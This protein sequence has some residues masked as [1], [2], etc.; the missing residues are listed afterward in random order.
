MDDSLYKQAVEIVRNDKKASTSYIQRKLRIGYNRAADLIDRMEAE[1]IVS[2]ADY[3]GRREVVGLE[4]K[5]SNEEDSLS[6]GKFLGSC[7]C[8]I[9]YFLL[10]LISFL[11]MIGCF[12]SGDVG[13]AAFGGLFAVFCGYRIY[14]KIEKKSIEIKKTY[15]IEDNYLYEKL[16]YSIWKSREVDAKKIKDIVGDE[17]KAEI[18][19]YRLEQEGLGKFESENKMILDFYRI[20]DKVKQTAYYLKREKEEKEVER[21]FKVCQHK[22]VL[23]RKYHQLVYED[24]YGIIKEDKYR[25]ELE[26]FVKNVLRKNE[27]ENS[28]SLSNEVDWVLKQVK[29]FLLNENEQEI[30]TPVKNPYD[31]EKQ[32]ADILNNHGWKAKATSKSLDQGVDVIAEKDGKKIAIQC[33]LYSQPVGNKAVQEVNAG[34]IYYKTDYAAVVSNNTYTISARQLAQNCGV[35]L[36]SVDELSN[37]DDLIFIQ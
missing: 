4:K 23:L 21:E 27:P 18:L 1:G 3:L 2:A 19:V 20:A 16:L 8:I 9:L 10:G 29:I 26:Y 11:V 28:Y 7:I 5:L 15:S 12:A 35:L 17:H 34:K 25:A 36:L 37:L 13:I 24:D 30:T 32:C 14:C 22:D 31:F 6:F 33:K